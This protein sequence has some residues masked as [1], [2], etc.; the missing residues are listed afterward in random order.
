MSAR[1]IFKDI[2]PLNTHGNR[3]MDAYE[4]NGDENDVIYKRPMSRVVKHSLRSRHPR[5]SV[6]TNNPYL[7]KEKITVRYMVCFAFTVGRAC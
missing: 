7:K 2:P 4:D 6:L 3:L 1:D 5:F